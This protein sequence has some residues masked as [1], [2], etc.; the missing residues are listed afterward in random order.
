M[1]KDYS[2]LIG[3]ILFIVSLVGWG[4]SAGKFYTKLETMDSNMKTLE[5][6]IDKQQDLLMEQQKFNGRVISYIEAEINSKK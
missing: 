1:K 4:F 3:Y 5:S 2:K 6:K